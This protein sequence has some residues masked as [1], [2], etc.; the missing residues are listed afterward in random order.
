VTS[1]GLSSHRVQEPLINHIILKAMNDPQLV[2][3][4]DNIVRRS[5]T[6]HADALNQSDC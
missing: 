5:S 4:I 1:L 3:D 6:E 2:I